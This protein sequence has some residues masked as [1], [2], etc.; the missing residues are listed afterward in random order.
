MQGVTRHA[1]VQGELPANM[2]QS[3][4]FLLRKSLPQNSLASV[5]YAVYGLGDSGMPITCLCHLMMAPDLRLQVW[6]WSK[7]HANW[8]H[9][10]QGTFNTMLSPK[11]W[12]GG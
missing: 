2:K 3:W 8:L 6:W 4:R 5:T 10:V 9:V 12:T 1:P 7:I 11:S